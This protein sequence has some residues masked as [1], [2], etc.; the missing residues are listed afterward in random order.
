MVLNSDKQNFS[1]ASSL[2]KEIALAEVWTAGK[3]EDS[4]K[5]DAGATATSTEM[6]IAL[7]HANM[8]PCFLPLHLFTMNH[9]HLKRMTASILFNLNSRKRPH[10]KIFIRIAGNSAR[11]Q[12]ACQHAYV[13]IQHDMLRDDPRPCMTR[14][15]L[16]LHLHH[17]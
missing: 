14:Y 17:R 6:Q 8:V 1:N 4:W 16:H 11:L 9:L 3:I 5:V 12:S 15:H 13:V 10:R 2:A 7:A